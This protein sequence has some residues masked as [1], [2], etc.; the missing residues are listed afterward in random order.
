[1]KEEL[2]LFDE[3]TRLVSLGGSFSEHLGRVAMPSVIEVLR[4]L[5][6]PTSFRKIVE[7]MGKGDRW[8]KA[9]I[10]AGRNAHLIDTDAVKGKRNS[11]YWLLEQVLE[12]GK[13]L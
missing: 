2:L 9:G 13:L 3:E 6:E 10:K 8:V 11:T 7:A 12:T 5:G 4:E 1:L